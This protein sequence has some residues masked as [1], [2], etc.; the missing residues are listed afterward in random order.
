[1]G[2]KRE[3]AGETDDTRWRSSVPMNCGHLYE[4]V[5]PAVAKGAEPDCNWCK[6]EGHKQECP[7][8]P[9][10]GRSQQDQQYDRQNSHQRLRVRYQRHASKHSASQQKK[11]TSTLISVRPG[12]ELSVGRAGFGF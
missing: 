8:P 1:M 12:L 11:E 3:I 7:I 9:T 2:L 4:S 10:P 5:L 6:S